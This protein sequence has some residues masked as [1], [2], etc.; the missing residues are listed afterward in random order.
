MSRHLLALSRDPAA[1]LLGLAVC[2]ACL[3]DVIG[4]PPFRY[5]PSLFAVRLGAVVL[6]IVI[7]VAT[8]AIFFAP[9]WRESVG[10]HAFVVQHACGLVG[11]AM[12][13]LIGGIMA[14]LV[15]SL[16]FESVPRMLVSL[17]FLWASMSLLWNLT[18]PH[19][20]RIQYE[21]AMKN[22]ASELSNPDHKP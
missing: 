18:T 19:L 8:F 20:D 11:M 3:L 15:S 9:R 7:A 22:M 16:P 13:V 21:Y 14:D 10:N 1:L 6:G 2:I 12:A 4:L 17:A 5:D